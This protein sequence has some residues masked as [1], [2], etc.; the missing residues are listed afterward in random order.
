MPSPAATPV[1][2][3][4]PMPHWYPAIITARAA[5]SRPREMAPS[6]RV[7]LLMVMSTVPPRMRKLTICRMVSSPLS[8]FRFQGEKAM[9]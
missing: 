5:E 4:T 8:S 6:K 2:A 7:I 9:W 1:A 3:P